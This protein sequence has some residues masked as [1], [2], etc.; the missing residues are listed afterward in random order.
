MT[1]RRFPAD[2]PERKKWQDPE[3]ILSSIGLRKGDVFI[4]VGCG[5]GFFALPAARYIGQAGRVCAFDINSD[6]I[7]RLKEQATTEGLSQVVAEVRA[8]EDAVVCEGC[9]DIVFFGNDLHDFSDPGQVIQNAFVML[10]PAGR[11]VNLDW[12]PIQMDFGPPLEKRFSVAR[13]EALIESGGLKIL[14]M[15][16]AGPYHYLILAAKEG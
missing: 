1:R 5:E 10:K 13:A 4:D 3:K 15:Q 14:S 11:L 12:K 7:A 2:D 9:G 8:A 6:A 16:D